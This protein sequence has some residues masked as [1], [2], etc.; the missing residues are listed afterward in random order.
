MH[1]HLPPPPSLGVRFLLIV[2][3]SIALGALSWHCFE[4][5]IND[6]KRRFPY[7]PDAPSEVARRGF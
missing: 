2:G 6:L 5:P 1:G 3:L 4:R 7:G